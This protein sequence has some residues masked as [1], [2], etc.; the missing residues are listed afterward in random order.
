MSAATRIECPHCH[1]HGS[2]TKALRPGI[3]LRCP[4]C[5]EEFRYQHQLGEALPTEV[6]QKSPLPSPA[7]K[8]DLGWSPEFAQSELVQHVSEATVTKAIAAS[9]KRGTGKLLIGAG[10][11]VLLGIALLTMYG[12]WSRREPAEGKPVSNSDAGPAAKAPLPPASKSWEDAI[13]EALRPGVVLR[14]T[15]GPCRWSTG[16][17]LPD[18]GG[19]KTPDDTGWG[20]LKFD[21]PRFGRQVVHVRLHRKVSLDALRLITKDVLLRTRPLYDYPTY[22]LFYTPWALG[23][24]KREPKESPDLEKVDAWAGSDLF[25]KPK[26]QLSVSVY[27]LTVEGEAVLTALPFPPGVKVIGSWL[28]NHLYPARP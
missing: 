15:Q 11:F 4:S 21:Q 18:E 24:L 2:T 9:H 6:E 19:S 3:K 14:A 16:Q 20:I 25:L 28:D 1:R 12:Q 13:E 5:H 22:V 8:V 7:P 27:G 26:P 10:V 23:E 17:V